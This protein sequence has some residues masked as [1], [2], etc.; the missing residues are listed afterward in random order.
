M[1]VP[2]LPLLLLLLRIGMVFGG[3]AVADGSGKEILVIDDL[4]E[5]GADIQ[6]VSGI[7][8]KPWEAGAVVYEYCAN[9]CCGCG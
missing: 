1:I 6:F 3:M 7:D 4:R 8:R 2:G 5:A 9:C